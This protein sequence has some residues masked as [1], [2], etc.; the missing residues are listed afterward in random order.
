V[1]KQRGSFILLV[2]VLT[3]FLASLSLLGMKNTIQNSKLTAGFISYKLAFSRAE[4]ALKK[5]EKQ[6]RMDEQLHIKA[7]EIVEAKGHKG[8]ITQDR[9][10]ISRVLLDDRRIWH[11]NKQTVVEAA[12]LAE[13][14][15]VTVTA[16]YRV[17]K[18]LLVS[19][20]G[21]THYYRVTAT[22]FDRE[23]LSVVSLQTIVSYQDK[24]QRVSWQQIP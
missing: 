5:A 4:V 11:D 7:A 3:S 12:K 6:L 2:L 9:L 22:G 21:T 18:L 14:S 13:Y 20:D 10:I 8:K 17:E 19:K 15:S 24:L 16:S 1:N 23:G